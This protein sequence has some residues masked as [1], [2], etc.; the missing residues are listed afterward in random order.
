MDY[1]F[2]YRFR[3]DYMSQVDEIKALLQGAAFETQKSVEYPLD[4]DVW[5]H[6]NIELHEVI[7]AMMRIEDAWVI[8]ETVNYLELYT[9]KRNHR[10]SDG[11]W[12]GELFG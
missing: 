11:D 8:R 10:R 4:I 2:T 12:S 9:G 7:K 5:M 6:T 1:K 3:A